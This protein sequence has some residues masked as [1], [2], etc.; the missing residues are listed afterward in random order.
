MNIRIEPF[1]VNQITPETYGGLRPAPLA[2]GLRDVENSANDVITYWGLYLD[3]KYITH[4]SSRE[5][6]ESTRDWMEKWLKTKQ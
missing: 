1:T 6:A 5:L 3:D 4:S 2:N